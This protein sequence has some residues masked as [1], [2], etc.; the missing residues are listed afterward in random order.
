[1]AAVIAWLSAWLTPARR[2]SIYAALAA[3]GAILVVLGWTTDSVV[4]GWVGVADAVLSVV[5]LILASVKA[6]RVDFTA[7]YAALAV[8]VGALKVV[9]VLQDGQA[10]HILDVLAAAIAAAPLLLAALRTSTSTPTGEPVKEYNAR[11]AVKL[12]PPEA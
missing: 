9:G 1:M 7:L 10:S 11:H 6:R 8:V 2:R 4:T 5:A 3:I 12:V